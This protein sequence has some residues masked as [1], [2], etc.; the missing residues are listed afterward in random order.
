M[1]SPRPRACVLDLPAYR[2]ASPASP[3]PGR[4]IRLNANEGALGPSP[5]AVAAVTAAMADAHAYPERGSATLAAALGRRH[6]I[7]PARVLVGNGSDELIQLVCQTFL[8]PGDEAIITQYGFVVFRL[9]IIAAGAT[10]VVAPDEGF[11]VS[12]RSILARVTPRTRLVFLANPNNPTGTY[13]PLAEVERLH[14]A[15]PP[16]VVLVLDAAYAEYV[17]RNDYEPGLGLCERAANVLMLRTFSKVYGLA[18]LR[19]GWCYGPAGLIE[20]LGRVKGAFNVNRAG[21]AAALAALDDEAFLERS[22]A[23]NDT[24][25]PWVQEE[26]RRLGLE[27]LPSV[28]N[29]F[30]LRLP[31]DPAKG[32]DA[33][34][35]FMAAR[36][37]LLREMHSYKLPNH[38]RLSVGTEAEMRTLVAAMKEFLDG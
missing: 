26:F 32:Q 25:L 7:D 5:A 31:E 24:W 13:L 23:H 20:P 9:S 17:R 16:D 18:G 2:A 3:P 36:G 29:F 6:G 35:A 34:L 12:V 15:L 21:Q 19:V 14:A 4:L 38:I 28:G 30:L 10:P 22:L 1:T 33:C 8:G 27:A 37:I 11:T